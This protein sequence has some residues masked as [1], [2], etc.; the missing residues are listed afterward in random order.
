MNALEIVSSVF[1]GGE[2]KSFSFLPGLSSLIKK[3][4][5]FIFCLAA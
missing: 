1:V 4:Q 2:N 3:V 5:K